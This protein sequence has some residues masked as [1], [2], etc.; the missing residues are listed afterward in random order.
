MAS[1]TKD[2]YLDLVSGKIKQTRAIN[3]NTGNPNEI[4]AT[5]SGGRININL[6]PTGLGAETVVLQTTENLA[7]GDF[8]TFTAG[9]PA[10]IRKAFGGASSP[11]PAFG[12][13]L[14]GYSTGADATVYTISQ[15]NNMLTGL[16]PGNDYYLATTVGAEGTITDSLTGP[17]AGNIIQYIGRA[18]TASSIVFM[19]V[20][21]VEQA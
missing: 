4:V 15:R 8:V 13:V 16:H 7:A 2:T 14:S 20:I 21:T 1:S 18:D 9:S 10:T 19:N 12:F 6:L 5:D 3:S 17:V 11:R